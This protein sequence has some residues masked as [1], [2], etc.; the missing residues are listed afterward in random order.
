MS[1]TQ[2]VL[3]CSW[4]KAEDNFYVKLSKPYVLFK[5]KELQFLY[6]YRMSKSSNHQ[7]AKCFFWLLDDTFK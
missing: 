5:K 3:L 2:F 1:Q 6:T 4:S 7:E